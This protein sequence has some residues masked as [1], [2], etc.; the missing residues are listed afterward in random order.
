[1]NNFDKIANFIMLAIKWT[2]SINTI[3]SRWLNVQDKK[4]LKRKCERYYLSTQRDRITV[5]FSSSVNL[6]FPSVY[7]QQK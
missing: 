6:F 3:I 4:T 5:I 7:V 1:M 2:V